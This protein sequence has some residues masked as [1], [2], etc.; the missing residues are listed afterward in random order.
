MHSGSPQRANISGASMDETREEWNVRFSEEWE[1]L[2]LELGGS[3][4]EQVI[5]G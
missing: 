2:L 3:P 5:G 1:R 4:F